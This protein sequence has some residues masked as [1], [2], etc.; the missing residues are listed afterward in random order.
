MSI[1]TPKHPVVPWDMVMGRIGGMVHLSAQIERDL[2]K[3]VLRLSRT[4]PPTGAGAAQVANIWIDHQSDV[5]AARPDHAELLGIA[6]ARIN[7]ARQL[8]NDLIHG[9]AGAQADP[10]GQ[11]GNAGYF[12][13]L[14]DRPGFIPFAWIDGLLPVMSHL[15]QI[16]A[17]LTDATRESDEGL[18]YRTYQGIRI[19]LLPPLPDGITFVQT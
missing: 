7:A 14:P 15:S 16:I 10:F 9:L 12:I 13:D 2:R 18:A 1:P 17:F 19:N 3:A 6:N 4:A 8:R 5:A 11:V